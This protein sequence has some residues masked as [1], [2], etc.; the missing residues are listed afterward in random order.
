MPSQ[1][2]KMQRI[3]IIGSA[4]SGK[5]TFARQF[6][7]IT[8]IPVYHLDVLHWNPGWIE[9]PRDQF[10]AKQ[11]AVIQKNQWRHLYQDQLLFYQL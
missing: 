9:T 1:V 11:K 6:G 8:K 7:K 5:S 2:E 10:I 3:A 4:G